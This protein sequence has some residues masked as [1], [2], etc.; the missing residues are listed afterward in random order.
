[1]ELIKKSVTEYIK[2]GEYFRDAREWY[3]KKYVFPTFE[4]SALAVVVA[5]ILLIVSGL[6]FNIY[7]LFPLKLQRQYISYVKSDGTDKIPMIIKANSQ[8]N[9]LQSILALLI[10]NYVLQREKYNYEEIKQQLLFVKNNS[11]RLLF[12]EFYESLSLSNANSLILKF[13][14]DAR[15]NAKPISVRFLNNNTVLVTFEAKAEGNKGEIIEDA[16]WESTIS[17]ESDKI[18]PQAAPGTRFGFIVTDYKA[19]QVKNNIEKVNK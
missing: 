11:T 6:I 19:R 17:F 7:Y 16:I 10:K 5:F 3:H 4:W 9:E 12:K 13:K 1:M 2:S 18:D 14:K 15:R 8:P